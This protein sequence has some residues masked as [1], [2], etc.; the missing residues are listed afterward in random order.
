[1]KYPYIDVLVK[2]S[3]DRA[4]F[5]DGVRPS[6]TDLSATC[7]APGPQDY[8]LDLAD[9]SKWKTEGLVPAR[10]AAQGVKAWVVSDANPSLEY[11]PLMDVDLSSYSQFFVRM[12]A[13]REIDHRAARIYYKT[14]AG[15][16][17]NDGMVLVIPL[18]ADGDM[19][20]YTYDLKLTGIRRSPLAGVKVVPIRPPSVSPRIL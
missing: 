7:P 10:P 17:F 15:Q 16:E 1:F 3:G 5:L 8:H 6:N 13:A 12:A 18:L 2:S 9:G 20:T 4:A 19:H 11:I 14:D